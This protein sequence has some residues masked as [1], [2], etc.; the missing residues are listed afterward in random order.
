MASK[1]DVVNLALTK[2]GQ[3]RVISIDDDVESAR[4]MRS[5]WDLTLDAC[6][7]EHPWKFAIV[8]DSLPA[9]ADAPLNTWSLQY[10]LPEACLKLVQVTTD[11]VFYV[12][13]VP[14]FELEGGRILTDEGAPLPVRYVTR[15]TN[16]GL[17]P[18]LFARAMAMSL[19]ADASEKL[20]GSSSKGEKAIAE[21]EMAI[22]TAKRASAI[23]RPPQRRTESSW[24]R[25]RGD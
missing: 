6:L 14:T 10:Q 21:R 16:V 25:A 13:D 9:L 3:D 8:R 2:L 5:L 23:E 20:T 18:P 11:W 1:T 12:M 19:A 22:R 4:V 17:W 24:L 7:A 15:V